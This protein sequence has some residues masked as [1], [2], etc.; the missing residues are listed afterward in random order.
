MTRERKPLSPPAR[1]SDVDAGAMTAAE[2]EARIQALRAERAVLAASINFYDA[3]PWPELR[4]RNRAA[5]ERCLQIEREERKLRAALPTLGP[6][7]T[8]RRSG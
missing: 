2:I 1:S 7:A 8:E 6:A 5:V 4:G 3:C